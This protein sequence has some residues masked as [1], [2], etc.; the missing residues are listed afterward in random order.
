MRIEL[1]IT[2]SKKFIS[3]ILSKLLTKPCKSGN[4]ISVR[5]VS[6]LRT[7]LGRTAKPPTS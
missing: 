1:V 7:L 2:N 5:N 6:H 3:K 4:I